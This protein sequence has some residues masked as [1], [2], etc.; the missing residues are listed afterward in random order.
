MTLVASDVACHEAANFNPIDERE[1]PSSE[2]EIIA[3]AQ[4]SKP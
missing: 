4:S 2:N 3:T 1:V